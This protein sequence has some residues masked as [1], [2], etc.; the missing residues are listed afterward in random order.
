MIVD[1]LAVTALVIMTAGS[2]RMPI[3]RR[4]VVVRI[5]ATSM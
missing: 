2:M 1:N 4:D 5:K 3:L